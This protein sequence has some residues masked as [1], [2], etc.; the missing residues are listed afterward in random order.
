MGSVRAGSLRWPWPL[1]TH[2]SVRRREVG[3]RLEAPPQGSHLV[4]PPLLVCA[5]VSPHPSPSVSS[6]PG[7]RPALAGW[8]SQ[9]RSQSSWVLFEAGASSASPPRDQP[10]RG[11]SVPILMPVCLSPV[12]P[13]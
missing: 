8:A 10:C 13:S 7:A 12:S 9:A 5:H 4:P 6:P 2:P 11:L 3:W 1:F